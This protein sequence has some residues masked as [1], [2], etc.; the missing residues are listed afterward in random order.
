M[1]V[2]AATRELNWGTELMSEQIG[3]GIFVPNRGKGV[4]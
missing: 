3:F 2:S 1:S 4:G